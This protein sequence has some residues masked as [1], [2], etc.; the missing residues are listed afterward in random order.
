MIKSTIAILILSFCI[1]TN[2]KAEDQSIVKLA[3]GQTMILLTTT[4]QVDV[5]QDLLIASLRF[6]NEDKTARSV[7]SSINEKMAVALPL[8][9]KIPSL[10][11]ETRQYYVQPIYNNKQSITKWHGSQTIIIQSDRPQDVLQLTSS[12]QDM[13]FLV[14]SLEYQ[15]SP[16]KQEEVHDGLMEET[17]TAINTRIKRISKTLNKPSFDLVELNVRDNI[18]TMPRMYNKATQ[19]MA[20]SSQA[21]TITPPSAE[22]GLTTVSLTIDAKAMVRP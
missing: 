8:I 20:L 12:L 6:D 22:P 2:T 1:L 16:Q 4:K 13:G 5:P 11:V 15:L 18:A 10:K 21:D 7:Q 3:D 17:I 14:N 9:K 19:A